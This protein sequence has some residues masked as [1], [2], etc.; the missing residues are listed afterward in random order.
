MALRHFLTL[1]LA[2]SAAASTTQ[3][4]DKASTELDSELVRFE[5]Y[6]DHK[7]SLGT[8]GAQ[9]LEVS[10]LC[11]LWLCL[12][13]DFTGECSQWCYYKNELQRF[14]E[15]KQREQTLSVKFTESDRCFFHATGEVGCDF[16]TLTSSKTWHQM[17]YK[18]KN[19]NFDANMKGKMG[20]MTCSDNTP[21]SGSV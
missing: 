15:R 11:D 18:G 4:D 10:R 2:T 12:G 19:G 3:T 1:F 20:C 9:A 13:P 17:I 5:D 8:D 21:R 14:D 6:L 16:D 7:A